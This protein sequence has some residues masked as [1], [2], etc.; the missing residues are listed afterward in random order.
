MS[1]FVDANHLQH[2]SLT[3]SFPRLKRP[4][5]AGPVPG[6]GGIF[7]VQLR[8]C[9]AFKIQSQGT[10]TKQLSKNSLVQCRAD[11]CC[12]Q[13]FFFLR[14]QSEH[15]KMKATKDGREYH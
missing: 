1:S 15:S 5:A 10:L 2:F 7:N 8:E 11:S 6:G 4:P 13:L 12:K 3:S 14:E 9:V